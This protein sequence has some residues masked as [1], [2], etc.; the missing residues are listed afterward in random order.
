MREM[1]ALTERPEVISLAGGL[2]DTGT[3]APELY[4]KL[5]SQRGRRVDRAGA[6]I[7]ADRGHGRQRPR[8][9]SR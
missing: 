2:P 6:A 4:A 9:S 1:M 5:M 3:F 7:R 8:A